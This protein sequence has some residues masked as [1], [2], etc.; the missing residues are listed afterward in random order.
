[1]T[2]QMTELFCEEELEEEAMEV[3]RSTFRARAKQPLPRHP[4]M[5]RLMRAPPAT[6][7]GERP[8]KRIRP[9]PVEEDEYY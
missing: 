6:R 8:I 1:M 4:G 2:Q 7:G 3:P 9:T 5:E